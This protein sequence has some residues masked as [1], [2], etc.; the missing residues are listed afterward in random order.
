MIRFAS[1]CLCKTWQSYVD[2]DDL[3][4]GADLD[5]FVEDIAA[6]VLS[7]S[8]HPELVDDLDSAG[9]ARFADILPKIHEL[10]DEEW[11]VYKRK[12]SLVAMYWL[13]ALQLILDLPISLIGLKKCDDFFAASSL[14]PSLGAK[15][16]SL[17]ESSTFAIERMTSLFVCHACLSYRI[18]CIPCCEIP[19]CSDCIPEKSDEYGIYTVCAYDGLTSRFSA[20]IVFLRSCL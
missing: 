12:D 2:E 19:L 17:A 6:L 8:R 15:L 3:P 18:V 9:K 1:F 10:C 7:C 13:S 16:Q 20:Y 5:R 11:A 14:L 4:T